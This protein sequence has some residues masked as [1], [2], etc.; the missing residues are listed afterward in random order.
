YKQGDLLES[1]NSHISLPDRRFQGYLRINWNIQ[2][3]ILGKCRTGAEKEPAPLLVKFKAIPIKIP[4]FFVKTEK[5]H[6]VFI[7]MAL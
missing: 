3:Q 5:Y 1:S 7:T 6:I 2:Q 4:M